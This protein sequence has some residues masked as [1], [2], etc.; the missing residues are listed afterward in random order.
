MTVLYPN[1]CYNEGCY[2]CSLA[3][4]VNPAVHMHGC[5]G[6]WG[7]RKFTRSIGFHRNYQLD[8]PQERVGPPPPPPPWKMLD[9]APWKI[10]VFCQLLPPPP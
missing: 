7:D 10:I 2:D 1:L 6:E 8:P 5:R 4:S 9:L 3:N